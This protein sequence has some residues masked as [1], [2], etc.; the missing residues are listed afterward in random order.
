MSDYY[1]QEGSLGARVC[2]WFLDDNLDE[3]LTS[4]DISQKFDVQNSGAVTSLMQRCVAAGLLTRELRGGAAVYAAGPR[5][6]AVR[7]ASEAAHQA[8]PAPQPRPALDMAVH[9][10]AGTPEQA[11]PKRKPPTRVPLPQIDTAAVPVERLPMPSHSSSNG[12]PR[13]WQLMLERLTEAGLCS[14][15]LPEAVRGALGAAALDYGRKH[16]RKF[17]IRKVDIH[18]IRIWRTQ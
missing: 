11:S 5:L 1:P 13:P 4:A 6:A 17:A 3:E 10:L 16:G 2:D 8:T 9:A 18:H 7:A 15:P 14:G 12:R